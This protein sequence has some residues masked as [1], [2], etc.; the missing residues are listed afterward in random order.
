MLATNTVL[1]AP[2]LSKNTIN[3]LLVSSL[4]FSFLLCHGLQNVH[5]VAHCL[6]LHFDADLINHACSTPPHLMLPAAPPS[7][8]TQP[9]AV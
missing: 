9:A 3:F 6:L 4:L 2:T 7:L 5:A 8:T 1:P